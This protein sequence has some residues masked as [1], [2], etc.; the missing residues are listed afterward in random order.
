VDRHVRPC[1]RA[2]GGTTFQ[3][4][5]TL[6]PFPRRCCRAAQ[7]PTCSPPFPARRSA[8]PRSK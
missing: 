3:A 8:A 5:L 2:S 7:A 4:S 6:P 1:R